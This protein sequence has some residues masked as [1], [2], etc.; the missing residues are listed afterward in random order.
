MAEQFIWT[1]A[2]GT[3]I[4]LTDQSAGY[5]ILAEG[6]RGLRGVPYEFSSSK[7]AGIDGETVDAVQASA[8]SPT[9]G[10]ILEASSVTDFRK[11]VRALVRAMRPKPGPGTLTVRTETG[12]TRQLT[13]YCAGGLEGDESKDTTL[14]GAWWKVALKLYAPDPW[15]Y[16]DP[17]SVSVGLGA[18]PVFFPITPMKLAPST[19]QGQFSIDL[20]DSDAPAY[21]LWT[22]TGPGSAVVLTNVTTNDTITVNASLAA[23]QQLIIDTRPGYQS[24]RRDDGTNLLG[25]VTSDPALWSLVEGPNTVTMA[26]TGSTS[27]S[28]IVGTYRP[29]YSGI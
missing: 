3:I 28:R 11:K 18:G 27:A 6:T 8:N 24:V 7:F 2:D 9:L 1:A 12:E 10:L 25:S 23:G 15:W 17:R 22:V 4:D 14:P 21:P 19:V 20:S 16:G 26:L 13:C 5:S 29:R